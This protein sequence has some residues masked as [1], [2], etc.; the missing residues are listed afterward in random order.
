MV[1]SKC[2]VVKINE[3]TV[4][5]NTKLAKKQWDKS[6]YA[7]AF[8]Y[9][10]KTDL[11]NPEMMRIA[12]FGYLYGH[13][14][15]VDEIMGKE[16]L[17]ASADAGDVFAM[18]EM[19]ILY[20]DGVAGFEQDYE[21]ALASFIK[22]DKS[23][24]SF[25]AGQI[26]WMYYEGRVAGEPDYGRARKWFAKG[27]KARD[28]WAL[29]G[30]GDCCYNGNGM[31]QDMVKAFRFYEKSAAGGNSAAWNNLGWMCEHGEGCD[32]DIERALDSYREANSA[33]DEQ[34]GANLNNLCSTLGDT[35]KVIDSARD[36]DVEAQFN[37]GYYYYNGQNGLPIDY[38]KSRVWYEQASK[39]GHPTA[40]SNLAWMLWYGEGGQPSRKR[41]ITLLRKSAKLGF[42]IAIRSLGQLYRA[43]FKDPMKAMKYFSDAAG[44]GDVC[45][46]IELGNMFWNGEVIKKDEAKAYT[47]Y[48]KAAEAGDSQGQ[49]NVAY[50]NE[51][52]TGTPVDIDAAE[53]WY[54]AAAELGYEG[55]DA[56]CDRIRRKKAH[57]SSLALVRG[58]EPMVS[59]L[60][61]EKKRVCAETIK[62]N[63]RLTK[64]R[65]L[66]EDY[67]S[68]FK[69]ARNADKEDKDVQFAIGKCY[70]YGFGVDKNGAEAVKWL[71]KSAD[72]GN[73]NAQ[74]ELAGMYHDGDA[75]S[76][77]YSKAYTLY[78]RSAAAGCL[79]GIIGLGN[80]LYDGEG[81]AKDVERALALFRV[82]ADMGSIECA[83]WLGDVYRNGSIVPQNVF[84]S[85]KYLEM[86]AGHGD[87]LSNEMLGEIYSIKK[88]GVLDYE[89]ALKF[90]RCAAENGNATAMFNIGAMYH[91][92]HGVGKD[93]ST[94]IEWYTRSA[95]AGNSK[96]IAVLKEKS[97]SNALFLADKQS[98]VPYKAFISY[99]RI[100]GR[101]YAR[102]LYLALR[103]MGIKTFFD[104]SSLRHGD[105]NED[106]LKAIE[107]AP[108]FI[109]MV[110]DGA[111]ERC[112]D[113]NDW[114]RKEIEYAEKLGKNIV[115]VAPTGHQQ[116]LSILP[117]TLADVRRKEVYRLDMENLFEESVN[118][119]VRECLRGV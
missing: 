13:G 50:M 11:E 92:G 87:V 37:L 105:F 73:A 88:Y 60:P 46:M 70:H 55:A 67:D 99:R 30:L 16:L 58:T 54:G 114:V 36:G 44:K 48:L 84:K 101:E 59:C 113:E 95:A 94:A 111:L 71:S 97:Y 39:L 40:M 56:A 86:A 74:A 2:K 9:A 23:G 85:V 98:T 75:V 119:I 10:V 17:V 38:K 31:P 112:F 78:E 61:E 69:Y 63:V 80:V 52:G 118:K 3:A 51:S 28:G 12:A 6:N 83:R 1:K 107:A 26:G 65:L 47:W 53:K 103:G 19:G 100:G 68:V 20:R 43:E 66:Q 8:S 104:Y 109:L 45:S 76:Q 34:A 82:A 96:A 72:Q 77:D 41:T 33:G 115:P 27:A 110:T 29:N 62:E 15:D 35:V 42:V 117:D 91:N 18:E 14:T 93:E 24:S 64:E 102:S 7:D 116:D 90:F 106:I 57:L 49:W 21:L 108:N 5:I 22:A 32:I 89:K 4:Q 81:V 25:A 79:P